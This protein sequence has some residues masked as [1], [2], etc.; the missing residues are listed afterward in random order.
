MIHNHSI[1][2]NTNQI[3][4]ESIV[5]GSKEGDH[6]DY[7]KDI[8]SLHILFHFP[9]DKMWYEQK[10]GTSGPAK[11]AYLPCNPQSTKIC[12]CLH[13]NCARQ[14]EPHLFLS[15]IVQSDWLISNQLQ[16]SL[17]VYQFGCS[18]SLFLIENS[19]KKSTK[20]F[21]TSQKQLNFG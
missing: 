17:N 3:I 6:R 10:G 11:C 14:P 20:S 4:V 9:I 12:R 21:L 7:Y 15:C 18:V 1:Y 5:F 16:Y 19:L 8:V 2:Y 13:V